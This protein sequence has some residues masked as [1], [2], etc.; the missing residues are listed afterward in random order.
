MVGFTPGVKK[1]FPWKGLS[2]GHV[3]ILNILNPFN[4][5]GM[6]EAT[7]SKFGKWNDY[8]KSHL[9]S[10]NLPSKLGWCRSRDIFKILNP[11]N[12]SAMNELHCLNLASRSTT[13]SPTSGVKFSLKGA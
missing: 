12:I 6:D 4:I 1:N 5:S 7:L 11:I 9:R 2:L 13:A 3:T 8:D 10:K